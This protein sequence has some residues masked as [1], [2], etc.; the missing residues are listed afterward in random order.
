MEA[1]DGT[2]LAPSNAAFDKVDLEEMSY[3]LGSDYLRAEMLGLHFVR[4]RLVSTDFKI[5]Q[6]GDKVKKLHPYHEDSRKGC[7]IA[8]ILNAG[9]LGHKSGLVSLLQRSTSNDC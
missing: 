8:D 5:Q 6:A 4:E 2:L 7:V 1:K 9:S 3:R